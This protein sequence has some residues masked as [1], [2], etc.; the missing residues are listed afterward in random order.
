MISSISDRKVEHAIWATGDPMKIVAD[1]GNAHAVTAGNFLLLVSDS[2]VIRIG[3]FPYVRDAGEVDRAI[4]GENGETDAIFGCFKDVREERA[5]VGG[6]V[7]VAV[8]ESN[9]AV[10]DFAEPAF[11]KAGGVFFIHCEP[12]FD[13]HGLEIIADQ[14]V[15]SSKIRDTEPE[16]VCLRDVETSLR[17]KP[18]ASGVFDKRKGDPGIALEPIVL[19]QATKRRGSVGELRQFLF[20]HGWQLLKTL[21]QFF[22]RDG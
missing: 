12:V 3:Q 21:I 22:R 10:S 5:V 19:N 11:G 13:R 17:I 4:V 14:F 18:E 1:E 2:V 20:R 7:P 8:F 15:R 9:D 6:T 16:P